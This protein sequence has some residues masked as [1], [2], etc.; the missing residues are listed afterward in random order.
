MLV[1]GCNTCGY[2]PLSACRC[3]DGKAETAK[4]LTEIGEMLLLAVSR[5]TDSERKKLGAALMK[6]IKKPIGRNK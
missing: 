6:N 5:L 4:T 2:A 1:R 3:G